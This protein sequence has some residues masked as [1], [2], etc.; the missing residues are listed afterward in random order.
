MFYDLY[1]ALFCQK[2]RGKEGAIP[3]CKWVNRTRQFMDTSVCPFPRLHIRKTFLPFCHLHCKTYS[4][5]LFLI[6]ILLPGSTDLLWQS[7]YSVPTLH[8]TPDHFIICLHVRLSVNN[9]NMG[10]KIVLQGNFF[11]CKKH[12]VFY[13]PEDVE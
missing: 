9:F 11:Y 8:H 6:N 5:Q 1:L 12:N 7:L 13:N 3:I 4:Q 2:E 10:G